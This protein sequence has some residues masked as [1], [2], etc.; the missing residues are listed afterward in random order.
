MQAR[1]SMPLPPM[2]QKKVESFIGGALLNPAG[3]DKW[4]HEW[5]ADEDRG[6]RADAQSEGKNR[7][8]GE[9]GRAQQRPNGKA[10]VLNQ[11]SVHVS[12]R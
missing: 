3:H 12:L 6:S 4:R 2:P 9:P 5:G 10:Q 11:I 1:G 8:H 7:R